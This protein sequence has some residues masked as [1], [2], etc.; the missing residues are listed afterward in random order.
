MQPSPRSS[1]QPQGGLSFF[2]RWGTWFQRS[3]AFSGSRPHELR[4]PVIETR[5]RPRP[6]RHPDPLQV[7]LK[8]AGGGT[9]GN[10]RGNH[11][12]PERKRPSPGR[13]APQ[14]LLDPGA[15]HRRDHDRSQFDPALLRDAGESAHPRRLGGGDGEGQRPHRA[16]IEVQGDHQGEPGRDP[17]VHHQGPDREV[18][19]LRASP[20]RSLPLLCLSL[21]AFLAASC[22]GEPTR[23][24]PD[25]NSPPTMNTPSAGTIV[26]YNPKPRAGSFKRGVPLTP[27]TITITTETGKGRRPDESAQTSAGAIPKE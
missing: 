1:R 21:L 19:G 12:E 22:S 26:Y 3:S 2:R 16:G 18:T 17:E 20:A 6:H 15:P 25:V 14:H 8:N 5:F 24:K 27:S 10:L 7:P 23:G 9:A 11:R 4:I 13:K